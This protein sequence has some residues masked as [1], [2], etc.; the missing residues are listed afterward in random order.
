MPPPLWT[1]PDQEKNQRLKKALPEAE[2]PIFS[3][4]KLALSI[5]TRSTE[6]IEPI[7]LA[8]LTPKSTYRYHFEEGGMNYKGMDILPNGIPSTLQLMSAQENER[9]RSTKEPVTNVGMHENTHVNE[10]C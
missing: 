4:P 2:S 10:P 9:K 5:D 6:T 1:L 7:H 3:V 8:I